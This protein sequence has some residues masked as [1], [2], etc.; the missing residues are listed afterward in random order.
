MPRGGQTGVHRIWNAQ[1]RMRHVD[2][3]TRNGATLGG[4]DLG[5]PAQP[6]LGATQPL[7][8]PLRV[9]RESR[10]VGRHSQ[11]DT[12]AISTTGVGHKVAQQKDN[13]GQYHY[14]EDMLALDRSRRHLWWYH[15][16]L[17]RSVLLKWE[18]W[19]RCLPSHPD[20]EVC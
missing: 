12:W 1:H 7:T 2:C 13:V 8:V 20:Q 19:M 11:V 16:P 15:Q 17:M 9:P 18:D 4:V 14:M 6:A 5:M 3:K 10:Y